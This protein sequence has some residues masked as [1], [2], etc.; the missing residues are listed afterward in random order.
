LSELEKKGNTISMYSEA[1]NI[2][3]LEEPV[4]SDADNLSIHVSLGKFG[5]I[6]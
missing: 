5:I 4:E 1:F 6:V 2:A 3:L